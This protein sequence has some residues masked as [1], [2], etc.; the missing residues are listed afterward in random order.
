[1]V[2]GDVSASVTEGQLLGAV[3][4]ILVAVAVG[5]VVRWVDDARIRAVRVF[6]LHDAAARPDNLHQVVR[7][8]RGV[9]QLGLVA[10]GVDD[11][12]EQAIR[13]V[14]EG[15]ESDPA[16]QPPGPGVPLLYV[17]VVAFPCGSTICR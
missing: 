1:M 6:V 15:E 2:C 5:V 8:G 17:S 10:V 13:A 3:V 12:G 16:A 14:A 9:H 7:A 4:G 11:G